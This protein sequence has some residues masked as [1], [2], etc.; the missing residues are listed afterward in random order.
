[1]YTWVRQVVSSGPMQ[2]PLW[3]FNLVILIGIL[4]FTIDM[5]LFL[6]N[7]IIYVVKKKRVYHFED[8]EI[9]P[10]EMVGG[11]EACN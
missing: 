4:L 8:I 2:T 9:E 1:M 3:I 5:I 6:A 10:E 11:K 7:H